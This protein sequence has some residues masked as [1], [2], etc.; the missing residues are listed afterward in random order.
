MLPELT[1]TRFNLNKKWLELLVY[2]DFYI[3][4]KN[5]FCHQDIHYFNTIAVIS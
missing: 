5:Y 2:K 1:K 3:K 4:I